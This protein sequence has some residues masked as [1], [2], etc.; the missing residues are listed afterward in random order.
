[1]DVDGTMTDGSI[2]ICESG[3][4]Y[5]SFNVKDGYAISQLLPQAGITPIVL[6]G[7]SSNIVSVRCKE[8]N[9]N[10]VLQG[11]KDKVGVLDSLLY[12]EKVNYSEVAY[13]GDDLNDLE[14][15]QRI[16]SYGGLI[17]CPSDA[18]DPV[19]LISDFVS[20][21]NGGRGAIREFVEWLL[22]D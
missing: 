2:N 22:Q 20:V 7:R 6:T 1:M 12:S 17:G 9:I 18:S 14:C 4:L 8:L 5:K 16:K 15:M 19:K 10:K 13:I 11:I 21:S 3:E